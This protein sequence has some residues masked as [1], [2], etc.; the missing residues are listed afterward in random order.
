MLALE[1]L[2]R[3]LALDEG[4]PLLVMTKS[5]I[6][7]RQGRVDDAVQ[8][9]GQL[10]TVDPGVQ[11]R[12]QVDFL[13]RQKKYSK[14]KLLAQKSEQSNASSSA[15]TLLLASV[16]EA[17]GLLTQA[18]SLVEHRLMVD[19]NNADLLLRS[20]LLSEKNNATDVAVMAY[21]D[22]INK[23]PRY[24]PA[25]FALGSL[26]DRLGEKN[27][28]QQSYQNVIAINDSFVPAINHL[29]YLFLESDRFE[30]ALSLALQAYRLSP[31][32]AGVLDTLGLAMLK[33]R[34]FDES[35][36]VLERARIQSQNNP[37][38]CFHLALAYIDMKRLDLA[39][40][41]LGRALKLDVFPEADRC[42]ELLNQM[43]S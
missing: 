14:A 26:R 13:I 36:R 8:L 23:Y 32:E 27:A 4:N 42:R 9:L 39:R 5:E 15:G 28:A 7:F 12:Q 17:E 22:L 35:S 25:H 43:R 10:E 19:P 11:S 31:G 6:L 40:V 29:A 34:R 33:N 1:N 2:N 18:H 30:D 20:A 3:G 41:E 16:L 21:Q 37:T 38:I 24:Y